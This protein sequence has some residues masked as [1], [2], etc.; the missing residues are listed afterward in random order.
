MERVRQDLRPVLLDFPGYDRDGF[1]N[2]RLDLRLLVAQHVDGAAGVE[3]ADDHIDPSSPELP[4]QVEGAW[5]LIG[6]DSHQPHDKLDRRAP[7]PANDFFYGEFFCSLIKGDD[8]NSKVA[9]YTIAFYLFGQTVQDVER[10]AR[11]HTFPEANHIAVIVVLGGFDQNNA[12]FLKRQLWRRLHDRLTT[13]CK[14]A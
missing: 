12:E 1:F 8:L 9:E 13:A 6:L 7:A 4:S 5:K 11:E 2:Q 14:L 10:V 3:S